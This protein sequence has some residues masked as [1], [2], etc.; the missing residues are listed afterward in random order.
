M[1]NYFSKAEQS[2]RC[3]KCTRLLDEE[4]LE[5]LNALRVAY[6]AP[7]NLSSAYRC[8]EYNSKV[9]RTGRRGP[10]TTG[11]AVDIKCAGSDAVR[12]MRLATD[13]GFHG[14]G[15]C[16]TGVWASR[17]IHLDDARPTPTMWS[18]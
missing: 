14:Y 5:K 8:P 4:F 2:C 13:L 17:F 7:I 12:V 3:G 16:Q 18:Y 9:S 6:G 15:V 1:R 10:H 11:K